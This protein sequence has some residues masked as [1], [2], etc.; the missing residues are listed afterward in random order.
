MH[1]LVFQHAPCEHPGIFRRFLAE[2]GHTWEAVNLDRGDA[3][4]LIDGYDALWVMGGP[5]DVWQEA[6]FPW[7]KHEKTYIHNAVAEKGLP[8]LGVCLGHQLLAEALGGSV[9][10]SENAVA[11]VFDV[12]LTEAGCTSILFDGLPETFKSLQWHRAEVK[13]L[14]PGGECLASSPDCAVQAMRWNRRAHAFQF[15]LEVE[16]DTIGDLA[17]I[18]QYVD[19]LIRVNGPDGVGAV[20]QACDAEMTRFN[21]MAERVYM[22]WLQTAAQ[23]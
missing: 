23:A 21:A 10:K 5:M 2:D 13:A 19:D 17:K 12:H 4:P 11:G 14:P 9:G 7:L 22:N 1:I 18:P 20:T 6:E 8:Y 16:S 15:H 3:M